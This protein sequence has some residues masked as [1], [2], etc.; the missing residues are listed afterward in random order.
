MDY[1]LKAILKVASEEDQEFAVKKL[2]LS[3]KKTDKIKS[4]AA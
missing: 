1:G 2:F 4:E 3:T